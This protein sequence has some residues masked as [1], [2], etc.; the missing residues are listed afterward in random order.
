MNRIVIVLAA[1]AVAALLVAIGLGLNLDSAAI[2][3]PHDEVAREA[4]RVHML[5]GIAAGLAVLLANSI[6]ATYFIGTSRW[7]REVSETYGLGTAYT[8]RS[9]RC[10]RRTFPYAVLS[11]LLAVAIVSL[12][13]AADPG[14]GLKAPAPLGLAWREWHLIGALAGTLVVAGGFVAEWTNIRRNQI[15]IGEVLAEV[16]RVRRARGLE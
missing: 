2:R 4:K 13:A 15:V 12:G 8:D 14:A 3:D 16:A 11:M 10:K 9:N 7:C 5:L 1:A 6:V